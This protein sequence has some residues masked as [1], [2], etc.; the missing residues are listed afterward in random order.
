MST[1]MYHTVNK[2]FNR[3]TSDMI[4]LCW[5]NELTAETFTDA[6]LHNLA[7]RTLL[8]DGELTLT[9]AEVLRASNLRHLWLHNEVA[10]KEAIVLVW[11]KLDE[12]RK[13]GAR[14]KPATAAAAPA[15]ALAAAP[16]V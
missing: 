8:E 14:K 13:P 10:R 3:R 1:A 5:R 11:K 15:A 9:A 2:T 16:P 12:Q 6:V 7:V 4:A